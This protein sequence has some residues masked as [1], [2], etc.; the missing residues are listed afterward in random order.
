MAQR[1]NINSMMTQATTLQTLNRGILP[2]NTHHKNLKCQVLNP[3]RTTNM[4]AS[5]IK[6]SLIPP[7]ITHS[8]WRTCLRSQLCTSIL[9]TPPNPAPTQF[10]SRLI[11]KPPFDKR[12][13]ICL[14]VLS[15]NVKPTYTLMP[16][17]ISWHSTPCSTHSPFVLQTSSIPKQV[18]WATNSGYTKPRARI[19]A[20]GA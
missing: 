20:P 6:T 10:T 5:V 13:F 11:S 19:L 8:N 1:L 7:T 2:G 15:S 18:V 4:Q 9:H 14:M 12:N 3:L 16:S 17:H